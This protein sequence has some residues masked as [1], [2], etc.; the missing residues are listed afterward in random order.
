MVLSLAFAQ[1]QGAKGFCPQKKVERIY[2]LPLA[3][4]GVDG[5]IWIYSSNAQLEKNEN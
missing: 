1:I 3:L 2:E 5:E 4:I